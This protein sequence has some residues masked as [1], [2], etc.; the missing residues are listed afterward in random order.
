[1]VQIIGGNPN[2]CRRFCGSTPLLVLVAVVIVLQTVWPRLSHRCKS[3]RV[4]WNN[5]GW[6]DVC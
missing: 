2:Y 5:D 3:L 1:M 4:H 6:T